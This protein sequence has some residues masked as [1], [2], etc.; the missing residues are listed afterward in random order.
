MD[1]E[2]RRDLLKLERDW[3]SYGA[4]PI[5]PAAMKGVE[6]LMALLRSVHPQVTP[7]NSGGLQVEWHEQ[8][9]DCEIEIGADGSVQP[10]E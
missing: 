6:R 4:R 9:I 7:T 2:N 1:W 3:N 5:E 8:G 10:F